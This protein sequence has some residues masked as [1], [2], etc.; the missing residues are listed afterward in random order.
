[1]CLDLWTISKEGEI[2]NQR[3]S[4]S[5]FFHGSYLP[6]RAHLFFLFVYPLE[7]FGVRPVVKSNVNLMYNKGTHPFRKSSHY[8]KWFLWNTKWVIDFLN[9]DHIEVEETSNN[10]SRKGKL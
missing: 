9:T 6:F 10:K 8:D 2:K 5:L 7:S 3:M 1:M 4:V